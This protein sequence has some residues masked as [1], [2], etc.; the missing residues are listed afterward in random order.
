MTR[1][2]PAC[3]KQI[4]SEQ[5]LREVHN[6][7]RR[8]YL[9]GGNAY[10]KAIAQSCK[11]VGGGLDTP[12][13]TIF[14]KPVCSTNEIILLCPLSILYKLYHKYTLAHITN[15]KL[16]LRTKVMLPRIHSNYSTKLAISI[17]WKP[18]QF[19]A[20]KVRKEKR[21]KLLINEG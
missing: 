16:A 11:R 7:L 13:T 2:C 3:K 6:P 4:I 20:G 14:V 12:P 19:F 10:I 9:V 8:L 5:H 1:K 18:C 21:E 17:E 15:K